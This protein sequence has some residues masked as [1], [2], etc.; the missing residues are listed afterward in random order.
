MITLLLKESGFSLWGQSCFCCL[1]KVRE[2]AQGGIPA[3]EC[4]RYQTSVLE[5]GGSLIF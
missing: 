4:R 2:E 1:L 3:P 5:Q